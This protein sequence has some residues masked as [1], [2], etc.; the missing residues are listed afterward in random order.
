M[1]LNPWSMSFP[2]FLDWIVL[3]FTK[4]SVSNSFPETKSVF[5]KIILFSLPYLFDPIE[6]YPYDQ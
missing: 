4:P 1:D 3:P 2:I 5:T 6:Q